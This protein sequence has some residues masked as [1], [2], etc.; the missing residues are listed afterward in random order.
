MFEDVEYLLLY[1]PSDKRSEYIPFMVC[2]VSQ[3]SWSKETYEHL[4]RGQGQMCA[5][6]CNS[7]V[8]MDEVEGVIIQCAKDSVFLEPARKHCIEIKRRRVPIQQL[9]DRVPRFATKKRQILPPPSSYFSNS[10]ETDDNWKGDDSVT[11]SQSSLHDASLAEASL[12]EL[13]PMVCT[14][15][16]TIN[17]LSS[18]NSHFSSSSQNSHSQS[19]TQSSENS[20]N[21]VGQHNI[22]LINKT[23]SNRGLRPYSIEGSYYLNALILKQLCAM[24]NLLKEQ[25]LNSKAPERDSQR[26]QIVTSNSVDEFIKMIQEN[27]ENDEFITSLS[28]VGGPNLK[29]NV[30][31]VM[32]TMMSDNVM[33]QFNR[34]GTS[35][36]LAFMPYEDVI[37]KVVR[38]AWPDATDHDINQC[39]VAALKQAADREALKSK[40]R[41]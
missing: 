3:T 28:L 11:L 41:S 15:S 19:L 12:P 29:K 2:H 8:D 21:S 32:K 34:P 36:K 27:S 10:D 5:V 4:N 14:E 18:Q 16:G 25:N 6:M 9:L 17:V 13:L 7:D 31:K 40:K 1:I 30:I 22:E 23:V 20:K 38:K 37:R 35:G 24:S 26:F 39:I 33:S